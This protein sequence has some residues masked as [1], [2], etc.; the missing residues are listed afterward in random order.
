MNKKTLRQL[1]EYLPDG[2]FRRIGKL[3]K[4]GTLGRVLVGSKHHTGYRVLKV[5]NKTLM[6]H[7]AVWIWHHGKC[8]AFL[9]HINRK[10][11]DNRI[12]NL[13]PIEN[14]KNLWNQGA[15]KNCAT[16]VKGLHWEKSKGY[17]VGSVQANGKRH[18][19]GHSKDREKVE[20]LLKL[21]REELHGKY[22][23]HT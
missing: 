10:R 18:R 21:K 1:F 7:R 14:T 23:T 11:D 12:E 2:S 5:A 20:R 17:W 8:P 3:G 13:R 16:G 4:S 9:D 15:Q 22:A 19:V 6:F